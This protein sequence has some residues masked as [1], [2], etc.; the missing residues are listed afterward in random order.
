MTWRLFENLNPWYYADAPKTIQPVLTLIRRQSG[1]EEVLGNLD[2]ANALYEARRCL[3]C[4]NCFECDTCYGICPDN[5][6]TKLGRASASSSSTT[7]AR[8]AGFVLPNAL[9][10]DR[11]GVRGYLIGG[12]RPMSTEIDHPFA[13]TLDVGTS[14]T[15]KNRLVADPAAGLCRSPAALQ[16][17]LPGRREYPGLAVSGRRG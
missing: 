6:V 15:N 13:I 14:L 5:A 16:Q 17:H 2:E 11:D 1:F 3:S 10:C 9:W 7:T 4:G 8:A 12:N